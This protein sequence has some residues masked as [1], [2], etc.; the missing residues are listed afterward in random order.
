MTEK[1]RDPLIAYM[2]T[3]EF[4]AGFL[5][6]LAEDRAQAERMRA[7]GL[8]GVVWEDGRCYRIWADGRRE[9]VPEEPDY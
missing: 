4:Q 5:R 3:E 9:F 2:E 6:V 1:K 8:I 7:A